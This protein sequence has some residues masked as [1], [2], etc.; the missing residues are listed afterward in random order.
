MNG[1]PGAENRNREPLASLRA[2]GSR[3]FAHTA[4]TN[5]RPKPGI[6]AHVS[7]RVNAMGS[8]GA[9]HKPIGVAGK[10]EPTTYIVSNE[11]EIGVRKRIESPKSQVTSSHYFDKK[12]FAHERTL[13]R[14]GSQATAQ[15]RQEMPPIKS[16]GV[17]R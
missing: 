5:Q 10:R 8:E 1:R 9:L 15:G 4:H 16:S 6:S 7:T 2:G 17:P 14:F 3:S 12:V 11:G 13:S